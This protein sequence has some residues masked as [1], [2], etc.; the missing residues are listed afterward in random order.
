MSYR[1]GYLTSYAVDKAIKETFHR[2]LVTLFHPSDIDFYFEYA[3]PDWRAMAFG[4]MH[5]S[6]AP[7][8]IGGN[9]L[10]FAGQL[11]KCGC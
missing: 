10:E 2:H 1:A 3:S 11:H 8:V 9:T 6:L 5:G 7:S 4:E